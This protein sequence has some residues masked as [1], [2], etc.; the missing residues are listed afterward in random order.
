MAAELVLLVGTTVSARL[1]E[2]RARA[3]AL[4]RVFDAAERTGGEAPS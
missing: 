4:K 1:R 3:D 2:A